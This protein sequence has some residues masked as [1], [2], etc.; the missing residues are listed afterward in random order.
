MNQLH[1]DRWQELGAHFGLAKDQLEEA[2]KSL[3]PTAE[4]LLAAKVKDINLKWSNIVEALLR[5]EEYEVAKGI[6]NEHGGLYHGVQCVCLTMDGS[7][8]R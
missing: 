4:V 5:V 1:A 2:K 6:A 7:N 3:N 8:L